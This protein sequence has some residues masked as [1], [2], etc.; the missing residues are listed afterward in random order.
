[1]AGVT[2]LS[3][4]TAVCSEIGLPIP[5][6]VVG[7]TSQ[8]VRQLVAYANMT[9]DQLRDEFDWPALRKLCTIT[10]VSG[11]AGY[12]I[13]ALDG[14]TTL[15]CSRI[16]Q[17]T[18]W[19]DTNSWYFLG[20]INDAEWNAWQYGVRTTPIRKIWRTTSDD[21]IE[22]FP[23]PTANGDSLKIS[24]ITSY[25][26]RTNAGVLQGSLIA[27]DDV[28]LYNDRMFVAGVKWR[29]LEQKGLPFALPKAEY[30]RML[31]ARKAASRPGRT[32]SLDGRRRGIHFVDYRNTP[33]TGYGP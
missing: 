16:V 5:S 10:T 23:T 30:D 22:M 19:D 8:Q 25:W 9:G 4:V 6:T 3:V 27:D 11:T 17:E 24:F 12:T 32:V 21:A 1:M 28:H 13:S 31:L 15:P 29:F 14:A 2:L 20:P 33:E 18:G 26:A 7:S